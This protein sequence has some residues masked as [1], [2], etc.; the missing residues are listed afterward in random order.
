M[1]LAGPTSSNNSGSTILS[2]AYGR[3]Q[4]QTV[5][6]GYSKV[7]T[8][9][10]AFKSLAFFLG[11]GYIY[12]DKRYLARAMTMGEAKRNALEAE[13]DAAQMASEL[14]ASFCVCGSV[15]TIADD[16]AV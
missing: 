6:M 10:I 3:I 14:H 2:I 8:I 16:G 12:V 5:D 1:A 11:L 9:G 7:L 15:R 4:D 13:M